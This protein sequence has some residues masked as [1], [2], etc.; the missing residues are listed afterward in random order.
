MSAILVSAFPGMGKTYAF[1]TLGK[2]L[3]ILD[4]DSSKFDK[5]DFP[6]N[7]IEHIKE[8]IANNDIIFIS[9]HKEVRDALEME[10]I[11]FDLFYPSKDRRNEFLE[12]Y[13]ARHF[14]RDLIMKIDNHWNEWIDE[15]ERDDNKNCH[16]HCLSHTGEFIGNNPMIMAYVNQVIKAKENKNN[17]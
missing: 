1:N 9:S 4:S 5:S 7:Y 15:I 2:Q 14:P 3:K 16:I 12:N 8:N 10:N 13:V 6:K 17:E 11:D